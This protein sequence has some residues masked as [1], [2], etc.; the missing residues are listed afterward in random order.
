MKPIITEHWTSNEWLQLICVFVLGALIYL[1]IAL[2]LKPL[3][4]KIN[5]N[6]P[7]KDYHRLQR[8]VYIPLMI[9]LLIPTIIVAVSLYKNPI[10]GFGHYHIDKTFVMA[11]DAE[12]NKKSTATLINKGEDKPYQIEISSKQAQYVNENQALELKTDK[13]IIRQKMNHKFTLTDFKN[14]PQNVYIRFL[15]SNNPK[16]WIKPNEKG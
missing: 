9:I 15:D 7:K 14:H 5:G 12:T 2:C 6:K 11:V 13:Q 1:L 16:E 4:K 3:L 10:I 8:I